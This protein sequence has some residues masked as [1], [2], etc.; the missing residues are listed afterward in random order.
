MTAASLIRTARRDAGFTQADLAARLGTTQSAVARLE[1]SDSNPT[2][3]ML[4]RALGATGRRLELARNRGRSGVDETQIV[5]RLQLTPAERLASFQAS[6]ANLNALVAGAR[7][8]D[9]SS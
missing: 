7:R 8:V 2:Y 9:D 4:V 1:R 6:Q 5:E 3:S